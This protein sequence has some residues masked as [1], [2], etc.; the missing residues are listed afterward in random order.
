MLLIIIFM[1]KW[2]RIPGGLAEFEGRSGKCGVRK[3]IECAGD[4]RAPFAVDCGERI[5][6]GMRDAGESIHIE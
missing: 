4:K 2:I 6:T 1:F 5:R 3:P